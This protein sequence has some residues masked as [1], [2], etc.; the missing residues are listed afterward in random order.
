M[1]R[2]ELA[3]FLRRGRARLDPSDVGL[4]SGP[5][6]RTPGLRRE[7]VASLAGMSVDYYTRLEQSRGP[8]PSRQMLTA[9]AR[10]LRLTD[11]E[12]DHL[13]HLT[14]E[15]PPRRDS[16]SAH[17]R[18]GLLLVLDRLHD[19]PAQ[20]VSDMGD[21]LAQN[22]MSRALAGDAFARPPQE[23]N[24]TRR[25]FLDPAARE[26]FP[27]EDLAEH[28]RS[29]VANLR[30]VTAARPDDPEPAA[31]VAELLSSSEEFACLW[32]EHE[33]ALRRSSTKRFRHPLVGLLEL[34]CEVLLSHEHQQLL[35]VHTARPGTE[36]YERLQ[37]LRV[38][39]LQDMSLSEP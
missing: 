36:S 6:R 7:E 28:A 8:R 14:G 9:L 11:D 38:V 37:L 19:T 5:R 18:P 26:L 15:E 1:N 31:L 35:I 10:A 22:A 3:D 34:D 23:R 12:R 33:V 13:F 16:P 2:A 25:F 32:D 20:V 17:V 30:A 21:V 27:P 29:Q 4:A 39:G 24:L